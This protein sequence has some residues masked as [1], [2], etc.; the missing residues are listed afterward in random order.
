MLK[1]LNYIENTREEYVQIT[2][3]KEAIENV[4]DNGIFF[5]LSLRTLE[6]IRRFNS[7]YTSLIEEGEESPTR[8]NQLVITSQSLEE[9]LVRLS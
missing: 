6:L 4:H 3:V 8:F 2:Q 1:Q 5:Q 7:L 9:E